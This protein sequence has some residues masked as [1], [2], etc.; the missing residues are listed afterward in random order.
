MRVLVVNAGSQTTKLSVVAGGEV[1]AERDSA[2]GAD[3][4][5]GLGGPAG[6][7]DLARGIADLAGSAG[8]LD[9]VGHRVVHGGP[10]FSSSV[11]VDDISWKSLALLADLAPLHNPAGLQGI[12]AARAALPEVPSVACFD[13]AFHSTLPAEASR[14]ALPA[15]WVERW[16][17][18]RYGFHGIS[19]AWAVRRAGALTGVAPETLR[20][21]ICHLGGGASVTAVGGGRS[22]DTTMGFTPLEGLVM[23]TRSGDVD[24]GAVLWAVEHGCSIEDAV[25]DLNHRSGLLGL[26]GGRSADMREV[27]ALRSAGDPAAVLAIAVYTH[28][29]RAKIAAMAAAAGGLDVLVFT[30]GVGEHSAQIR[31]ETCAGLGW[32]GVSVADPSTRASDSGDRAVSP[33]GAAVTVLVVA[34]REDLQIAG[35]CERVLG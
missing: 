18:R 25:F 34:A 3:G 23:A 10:D 33:P 35:E 9:A 1:V 28:R 11:I 31:T 4:P 26:T 22:L 16:G 29:L 2:A 5:A 21:V 20:I 6:V 8:P 27:L 12:E 15:D 19:C 13:T 14:Y 17:L 30:G 32:M 7:A 24:P